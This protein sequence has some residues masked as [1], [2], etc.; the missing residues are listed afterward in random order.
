MPTFRIWYVGTEDFAIE[1]ASSELEACQKTGRNSEEC[2]VQRIPEE[3]IV[4]K[5]RS[6]S[7]AAAI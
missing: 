2:E 3:N 1:E 4:G 5:M 7:L 6:D